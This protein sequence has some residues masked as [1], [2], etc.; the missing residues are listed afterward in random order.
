MKKPSPSSEGG[1]SLIELMVALT[2]FAIG[3]LGLAYLQVALIRQNSGA[4]YMAQASLAANQMLG[5]IW[6]AGRSNLGNFNGM[7][8]CTNSLPGAG[9]AAVVAAAWS[10]FVANTLP[11]G[12]GSVQ[13]YTPNGSATTGT[14]ITPPAIATVSVQWG[15]PMGGQQQMNVSTEVLLP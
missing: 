11:Q 7:N 9:N 14:N 15:T 8:T 6:A 13:F 1:F 4:Q 10:T 5:T 12:C 3:L 2:I